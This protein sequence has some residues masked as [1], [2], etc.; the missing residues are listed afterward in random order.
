LSVFYGKNGGE[1]VIC[2]PGGDTN[3]SDATGSVD[4]ARRHVIFSIIIVIIMIFEVF[5]SYVND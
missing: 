4:R 2:R 3:P 5:L 1:T